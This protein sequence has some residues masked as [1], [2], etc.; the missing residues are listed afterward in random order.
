MNTKLKLDKPVSFVRGQEPVSE[1]GLTAVLLQRELTESRVTGEDGEETV[2][3]KKVFTASWQID[4]GAGLHGMIR[5]NEELP[6]ELGEQLLAFVEAK[7][8]AKIEE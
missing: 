2:T 7:S 1:V 3:K 6:K 5:V 4:T 8:R